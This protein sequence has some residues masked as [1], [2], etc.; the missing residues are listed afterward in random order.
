MRVAQ[1]MK[2]TRVDATGNAIAFGSV[3]KRAVQLRARVFWIMCKAGR[4]IADG[5]ASKR[6]EIEKNTKN[7]NKNPWT[8]TLH[9]TYLFVPTNSRKHTHGN[10]QLIPSLNDREL[11]RNG[12]VRQLRTGTC[13]LE[14]GSLV[15][16]IV[17]IDCASV[18]APATERVAECP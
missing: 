14:Q 8:S 3:H 16:I 11:L 7:I 15:L 1:A 13:L 10:R 17:R 2:R 4:E 12:L 5:S 6:Q 9:Q 18:A